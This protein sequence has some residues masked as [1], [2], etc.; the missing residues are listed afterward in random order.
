M[1]VTAIDVSYCQTGVDYNKVKNSGIDAV[2]I[3]AG[4]GK[5]TY[6]KDSEFETHYRNA[7]KA[8]LAVGVY[9]YSYAYS[10]A[11]AKQEAKVC[12]ACIRGKTLELPVY[13]D[14]EESGQT[15]LG[16][17]ALTNI[18]IAFCD[19]IKS[20]GYRAGVYSNLNWLNNHLD[21]ERLRSKYSIWLAQWSSNPSKSCDIWQNA[22]NGRINGINGN[23]DT[24][25]IINNN[26]IKKS[27]TGDEEEMIKYGS[28]NTA[29]LAFK[30]QL[31]TLYN[32]KIIKTKVDNS[33]GFGDG[34]LK[35]VKEAQKAGNITA[36][37]VVNEKT[38]NVIYHLINDCNWSKDNK[39]ANAKKALG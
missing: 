32:M 28:H 29:T 13:Y 4:F 9:W 18:A 37:G 35:A 36:N 22:D 10:V 8:G 31:I 19:A 33:N 24:D 14:L 5:E 16:M 27:S 3:R 6:Q 30:K 2:I 17:S 23:V 7:K 39:I 1:K 11:E 34:T 12:L 38:V 26:I 20:G 15:R 21:Y 25:V